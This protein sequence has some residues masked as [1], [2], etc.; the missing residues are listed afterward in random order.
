MLSSDISIHNQGI[1]LIMQ[2]VKN[3]MLFICELPLFLRP[4]ASLTPLLCCFYS[5]LIL[6]L[7]FGQFH[8]P[9]KYCK[10]TNKQGKEKNI[11]K[12]NIFRLNPKWILYNIIIMLQMIDDIGNKINGLSISSS[13]NLYLPLLCHLRHIYSVIL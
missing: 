12:R 13:I 3:D 5:K 7:T 10:P 1:A 8:Q 2:S 9:E 6:V 4:N 11:Y